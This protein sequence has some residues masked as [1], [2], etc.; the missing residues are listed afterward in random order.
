MVGV[1][2][3]VGSMDGS[4]T[5]NSVNVGRDQIGGDR[6]VDNSNNSDNS[7]NAG[8]DYA[9]RDLYRESCVGPDCRYAS[10]GPHDINRDDDSKTDNSDNSDNSNNGDNSTASAAENAE[11]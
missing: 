4:Y 10:P 5:D 2:K 11:D 6:T 7:T 3:T 9:G 1:V 8:G